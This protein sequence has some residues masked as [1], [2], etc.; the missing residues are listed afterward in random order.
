MVKFFLL[1][2]IIALALG[3][4]TLVFLRKKRILEYCIDRRQKISYWRFVAQSLLLLL[5]AILAGLA[6]LAPVHYAQ[7]KSIQKACDGIGIVIAID[8]SRSMNIED[9]GIIDKETRLERS[10]K[11]I[12]RF[13]KDCPSGVYYGLSGFTEHAMPHCFP[14]TQ[15]KSGIVSKVCSL[16][17][18]HFTQ[19]ANLFSPIDQGLEMFRFAEKEGL[20]FKRKIILVFTDGSGPEDGSEPTEWKPWKPRNALGAGVS[21]R[22]QYSLKLKETNT[23][24]Y[25]I[26]MGEKKL[27]IIPDYSVSS[28]KYKVNGKEVYSGLSGNSL[29]SLASALG[30]KYF[31]YR[32]EKGLFQDLR[33]EIKDYSIIVGKEISETKAFNCSAY[34]LLAAFVI[35]LYLSLLNEK[36]ILTD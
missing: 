10:Q 32:E 2:I 18:L 6:I 11:I 26:G 30:G 23:I 12:S 5:L 20:K 15:E 25:F 31:H 17:T 36:G 1:F 33:K 7:I 14:L 35:G 16:N 29:K 3:I 34:F 27:S 4:N 22:K 21:E 24:V 28:G 8:S 19:G 9:I 13:I